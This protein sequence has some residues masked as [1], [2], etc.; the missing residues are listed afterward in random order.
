MEPLD[1]SGLGSIPAGWSRPSDLVIARRL[2]VQRDGPYWGP[3]SGDRVADWAHHLYGS[4]ATARRECRG[5]GPIHHWKVGVRGCRPSRERASG[6]AHFAAAHVAWG[7]AGGS[8][9]R[10][11]QRRADLQL[12]P[13]LAG[14]RTATGPAVRLARA[15]Q[16]DLLLHVQRGHNRRAGGD[17]CFASSH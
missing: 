16:L 8:V 10:S 17:H 6:A 9:D 4:I 11:P 12:V 1:P 2:A 15:A 5:R 3:H 13:I 14:D 7:L